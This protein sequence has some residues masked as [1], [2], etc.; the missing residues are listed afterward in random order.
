MYKLF[1]S[2]MIYNV[3][4]AWKSHKMWEN[5]KIVTFM[6]HWSFAKYCWE[7]NEEHVVADFFWQ[8]SSLIP[9]LF[10]LKS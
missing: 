4:F 10:C 9:F 2:P 7:V 6:N 8:L 1:E 3:S 5:G